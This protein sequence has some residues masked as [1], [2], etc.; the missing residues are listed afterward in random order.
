MKMAIKKIYYLTILIVFQG[1]VIIPSFKTIYTSP[2]LNGILINKDSLPI[3]NVVVYFDDYQNIT[4]TTDKNGF[5]HIESQTKFEKFKIIAMD[6]PFSIIHLIL[7]STSI[8]DS[9]IMEIPFSHGKTN[10]VIIMDTIMV[11]ID[12]IMNQKRIS[13]IDLD[14]GITLVGT[15][16]KFDQSKHEYDTCDSGLG[17]K[18][19]CLIDG[20]IW[21]GSDAG[22]ELP[23]NQLKS[24]TIK[25]DGHEIELETSG[26]FNVSFGNYFRDKQ[27]LLKKNGED[28]I[29]EGMFSDGAGAYIVQWKIVKGKSERIKISNNEKDF[30]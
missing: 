20:K 3:E 7:K 22:M 5:F 12:S 9:I 1:C 13:S 2:E 24:L 21:Y 11:D 23:R 30:D 27:F 25:I 4:D 29:L 18:Y 10:K 26:M 14:N 8:P 6:P 28:Y 17:W 16:E 15:I 19:I